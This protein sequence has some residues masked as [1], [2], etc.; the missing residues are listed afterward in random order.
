MDFPRIKM[1]IPLLF[2]I[3][4]ATSGCGNKDDSSPST[5]DAHSSSYSN[6]SYANSYDENEVDESEIE[7]INQEKQDVID[8]QDDLNRS[9]Q[10][11]SYGDWRNDIPT[12]QQKLRDL[13]DVND[14]L[15]SLDSAAASDMDWEIQRM[16]RE[17]SRLEEEN[18]QEVVPDLESTNRAIEGASDDIGS[19]ID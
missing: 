7:E 17:L 11:L 18:W 6:S 16:K 3:I 1:L 12:V 14:Q 8:A 9:V 2:G 13:E 15:N 10:A 5:Y 4:L 19:S